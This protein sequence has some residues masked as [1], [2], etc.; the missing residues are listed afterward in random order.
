MMKLTS[1]QVVVR[2]PVQFESIL[3]VPV[4]WPRTVMTAR[5]D[6]PPVFAT[7][8]AMFVLLSVVSLKPAAHVV[9]NGAAAKAADVI[10]PAALKEPPPPPE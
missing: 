10:A 4:D 2:V 1:L 5:S 8:A 9:A 3:D 7:L 6:V